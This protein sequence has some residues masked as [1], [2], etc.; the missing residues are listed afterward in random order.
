MELGKLQDLVVNTINDTEIIL[1]DALQN[2]VAMAKI[3]TTDE[4]VEVGQSLNVFIYKDQDE[5][6]ATSEIPYAQAG[7]YALL[8]ILEQ[9]NAG[10]FA[11]WGIV[12]DLFI[13][14]RLQHKELQKGQTYLCYVFLDEERQEVIGTTK[15]LSLENG[16]VTGLSKN[17]EVDLIVATETQL[18]FVVIIN[19]TYKGLIY[20]NQVFGEVKI[21]DRI[22]GYAQQIREDGKI[23]L[24]LQPTG[25]EQIDEY[26]K[27]VLSAINNSLGTL[28]LSDKSSPEEI[29]AQ[30]GMS[31]KNFK[32]AIGALYKQKLI[33]I[34]E[35][36][37]ERA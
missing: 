29:K 33:E 13:P 31:K 30:L 25:Y 20:H 22:K 7:Q 35:D 36:K 27:K 17:Q 12:K 9:T 19:Q 10:A 1:S 21:H 18:G 11:D 32:K 37:I 34:F 15:I 2:T 4:A 14:K 8:E 5:Y 24:S 3:F 23:D 6:R 28:M 26:S 16:P